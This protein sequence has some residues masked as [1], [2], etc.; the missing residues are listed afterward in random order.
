MGGAAGT[1]A[2]LGAYGGKGREGGRERRGAGADKPRESTRSGSIP[3]LA[4]DARRDLWSAQ[5]MP[6]A[7][8]SVRAAHGS[9]AAW[10]SG[11]R[12]S[13]SKGLPTAGATVAWQESG[14]V[15]GTRRPCT[16]TG[17]S[18][19]SLYIRIASVTFK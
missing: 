13:R 9:E 19:S 1:A 15:G 2:G 18:R 8:L 16:Y 12:Q 5:V 3:A 10:G 7:A 14:G 6:S 11:E 17:G 4:D